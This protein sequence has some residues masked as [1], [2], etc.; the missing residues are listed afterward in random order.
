M[1]ALSTT[2]PINLRPWHSQLRI[3]IRLPPKWDAD[4]WIKGDL[5]Y[6]VSWNRIDLIRLGKDLSGKR[7]YQMEPLPTAEFQI[8]QSCV[9]AALDL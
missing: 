7:V 9:R 5:V 6:A 3:P 1:V 4:C 8:V 2:S